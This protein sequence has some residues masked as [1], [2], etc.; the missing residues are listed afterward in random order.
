MKYL[1]TAILAL[2]ASMCSIVYAQPTGSNTPTSERINSLKTQTAALRMEM[3]AARAED[4]V[5]KAVDKFCSSVN[6]ASYVICSDPFA[7]NGQSTAVK[8]PANK[9]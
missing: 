8:Q 9:R 2:S 3:K 7:R 5:R 1:L 4:R 6:D